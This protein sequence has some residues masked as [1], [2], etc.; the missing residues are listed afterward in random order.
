MTDTLNRDSKIP[1][2]IRKS[3]LCRQT[4]YWNK[5]TKCYQI[6]TVIAKYRLRYSEGQLVTM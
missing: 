3:C 1:Q 6:V 2:N 4:V 5:Q